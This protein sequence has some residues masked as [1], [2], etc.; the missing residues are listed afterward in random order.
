MYRHADKTLFTTTIKYIIIFYIDIFSEGGYFTAHL[1]F[2]EEYPQRPPKLKF[3]SEMWHPN[4]EIYI[5]I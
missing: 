1:T 4:G 2:P 3:V 5:L